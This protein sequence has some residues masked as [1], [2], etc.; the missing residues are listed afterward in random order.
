M[1]TILFLYLLR[2]AVR[3]RG[4]HTQTRGFI[5]RHQRGVLSETTP[6][7]EHSTARREWE[8]ARVDSGTIQGVTA[9]NTNEDI[10][11]AL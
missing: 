11:W 9:H 5:P 10:I 1:F 2:G 7:G 8:R 3:L 4:T 6:T